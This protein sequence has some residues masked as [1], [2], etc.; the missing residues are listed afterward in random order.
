ML[1]AYRDF[2]LFDPSTTAPPLAIA[3]GAN[4]DDA[5]AV[6][7]SDL[8][9]YGGALHTARI[10]GEARAVSVPLFA[11]SSSDAAIINQWWRAQSA[12]VFLV[13]SSSPPESTLRVRIA[14][15]ALPLGQAYASRLDLFTGGLILREA[16]GQDYLTGRPFQL[17]GAGVIGQLDNIYDRLI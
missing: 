11:V 2:W 14:N 6:R 16:V 3:P 1:S 4:L 10:V 7:R 15:Q 12:L 17:D 5:I 8:V 13:N 9:T